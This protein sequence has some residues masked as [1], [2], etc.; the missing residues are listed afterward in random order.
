MFMYARPGQLLM[1]VK[2][3]VSSSIESSHDTLKTHV[4]RKKFTAFSEGSDSSL[5]RYLQL[6]SQYPS[7]S[8]GM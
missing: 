8:W 4:R 2:T 7:L 6:L 5:S 1:E 3:M